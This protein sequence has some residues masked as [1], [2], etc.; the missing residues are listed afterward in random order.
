MPYN[1]GIRIQENPTSIPTPVLTEA[2]VPVFFG[3]AP[4][5]LLPDPSQAVNKLI[6]CNSFA[7]AQEKLGYSEDYDNYTLCAAMDTMFKLFGVGP[8]VFV[9]VLDPSDV[10]HTDTYTETITL[11]N[12]IG[13]GTSLGVLLGTTL[14]VTD[15]NDV[16]L[17]IETDYTVALNESGYP[18]FNV[19][20]V[21]VTGIKVSGKKLK[22]SGVTN[23]DVIG[24]YNSST[25]VSTGIQLAD[26][27]YPE[28]G[29]LPTLLAAPGYSKV[30]VVGL[31]LSEKAYRISS[32]FRCECVLDIDASS[33]GAKVYSDVAS[34]KAAAGF[35]NENMILVWPMV[36]YNGKKI[37]Y[38]ALYVAVA[39]ATDI[40]NDNV[41][42]LSPSNKDLKVSA[43]CDADGNNIFLDDDQAN[44]LNGNGV[45]TAVNHNGFR[46]WG[47]NTAAYPDNTDPKD[48]WIGVRRFF[49]WWG[50]RFIT[51]YLE[52]VD[53]NA[54]YRLIE[55]FVD[56]ENVFANSLVSSGKC[57][58]LRMEYRQEDNQ[59]DDVIDGKIVFREF[60][61]PYNPAEDILD[62]LEYDPSMV[63][64][65]LGGGES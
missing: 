45:V 64:A 33:S 6:L 20:K 65:A 49:S 26:K 32:R 61:A 43:V 39:I 35:V 10:D 19:T 28:L 23:A 42:S 41:P 5:N 29:M 37:P 47:N 8:A 57:A 53:S 63:E 24:S 7:E 31:A 48:R 22:P 40:S 59:I 16:A 4:I 27:V 58:G 13:V 25:G 21:G 2:G 46:S 34:A 60:L 17:V 38:S 3:T 52:K 36:K 54:D 56:S 50:N 9:N 11:S 62:I 12:K 30:S 18:V 44:E 51:T 15:S 55:S 14:S 1:H